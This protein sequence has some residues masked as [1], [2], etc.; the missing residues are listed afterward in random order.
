MDRDSRTFACLACFTAALLCG[1]DG[2]EKGVMVDA[3]ALPVILDHL[4]D[5]QDTPC[6]KS[7]TEGDDDRI[8]QSSTRGA[9]A[10][11]VHQ[12]VPSS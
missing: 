3:L 6:N 11:T 9:H 7:D 2:A 5:A 1:V 10:S 12:P 4:S 8:Y